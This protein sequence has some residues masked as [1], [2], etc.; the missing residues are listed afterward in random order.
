MK[1]KKYLDIVT[2]LILLVSGCNS[3]LNRVDGS[4][5]VRYSSISDNALPIDFEK[6]SNIIFDMILNPGVP[7]VNYGVL[8]VQKNAVTVSQYALSCYDYYISTG[9]ITYYEK[10]L[11]QV[12][13]LMNPSN[14]S[15]IDDYYLYEYNFDWDHYGL[16][17]PWYSAMAQG[18]VVSVLARYYLEVKDV[19]I[20]K[21]MKKVLAPL[22]VER[23]VDDHGL[24][25]MTPENGIWFEE[26]PSLEPS[27]VL[28]GYIFALFGLLE[29][30]LIVPTD[31]K[32]VKLSE[33][34]V[35][36]LL[37][38]L[39]Y[40]DTGSWSNYDRYGSSPTKASDFYMDIHVDQLFQLWEITNLELFKTYAEKW[41]RYIEEN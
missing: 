36:S 14:Y 23:V 15:Q 18:Q 10:Y 26:Y 39:N 2:V 13:W 34:G 3:D 6:D 30:S 20:L 11:L 25:V 1:N 40:Y 21:F 9:N 24:M 28:N 27:L 32:Y 8:G 19:N 12:A 4:L 31:I 16:K 38:S 35:A 22:A 29:Y 33:N 41:Q 7:Y 5:I 37:S 17:S